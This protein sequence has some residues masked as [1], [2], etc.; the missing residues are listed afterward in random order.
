MALIADG[1][2]IAAALVAALYC[3][4][5]SARIRA[6]KDLDRGLGAAI[7]QLSHQVDGMQGALGEAKRVSGASVKELRELTARAEMAA[8][9]LELLLAALH[10]RGDGDA[11]P[12]AKAVRPPREMAREAAGGGAGSVRQA[13]K[14]LRAA[15]APEAV[16]G[17]GAAAAGAAQADEA[18]EAL[19]RRLRS[20]FGAAGA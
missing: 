9:R 10:E 8:G 18:T 13:E 19:R 20:L 1:L 7:A 15:A 16:P 6:L 14:G 3:L 11:R 5:L 17:T 12:V 4:V 2:M